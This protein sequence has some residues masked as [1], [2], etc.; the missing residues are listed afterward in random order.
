MLDD[1][2]A[3][4]TTMLNNLFIARSHIHWVSIKRGSAILVCST[5]RTNYS[6]FR[7]TDDIG[8]ARGRR[9][10]VQMRPQGEIPSNVVPFNIVLLQA[11]CI[12]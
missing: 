11:L 7:P 3:D 6:R 12:K 5:A 9:G 2:R 4:G 10:R 1:G 8:V